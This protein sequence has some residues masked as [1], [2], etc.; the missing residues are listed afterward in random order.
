ESVAL[1]SSVE[2]RMASLTTIRRQGVAAEPNVIPLIDVLLVLL[3]VFMIAN[4][5]LR[6]VL[7][8]PG[9]T[10]VGCEVWTSARIDRPRTPSGARVRDQPAA[11]SRPTWMRS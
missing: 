6:H 11:G 8:V 3:V 5:R 1:S 9:T 4:S 10:A 7:E 2:R